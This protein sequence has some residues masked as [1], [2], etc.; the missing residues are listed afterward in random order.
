MAETRACLCYFKLV[1]TSHMLCWATEQSNSLKTGAWCGQCSAKLPAALTLP[2]ILTNESDLPWGSPS[3]AS[4]SLDL[5]QHIHSI[6]HL[7]NTCQGQAWYW[8][9]KRNRKE[10]PTIPTLSDLSVKSDSWEFSQPTLPA[11]HCPQEFAIASYCFRSSTNN[12]AWL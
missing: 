9:F 7:S 11:G 5:L 6:Q 1:I 4:V 10:R 3:L 2:H 8:P 12:S